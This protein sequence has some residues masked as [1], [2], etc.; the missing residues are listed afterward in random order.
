M[1]AKPI[2][3]RTIRASHSGG[4]KKR[5]ALLPPDLARSSSAGQR[6]IGGD[7]RCGCRKRHLETGANHG[8]WRDQDDQDCGQRDIA[9]GQCRPVGEN[10][11]QHDN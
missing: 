3:P 11:D 9:H 1:I 2:S 8:R 5:W 7:Q 4:L 10:C 6:G